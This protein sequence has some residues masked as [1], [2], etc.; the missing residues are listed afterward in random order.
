MSKVKNKIQDQVI[1]FFENDQYYKNIRNMAIIAHVDHG[2]STLT[3][4]LLAHTKMLDAD[5]VGATMTD[6][7]KQERERG[8]TINNATISV[9]DRGTLFNII[10]TPGHVDFGVE[11]AKSLRSIDTAVLVMDCVEGVMVQTEAVISQAIKE[12][13]ELVLLINKVD[14]LIMLKKTPTEIALNFQKNIKNV[15]NLIKKLT[16]MQKSY[17]STD[18][19]VIY[20][21]SL[22]KWGFTLEKPT[23]IDQ[24]KAVID[25]ISYISDCVKNNLDL[26]ESHN[27]ASLVF[28]SVRKLQNPINAHPANIKHHFKDNMGVVTEEFLN[29]PIKDVFRALITDIK[30]DHTVGLTHTIRVLSGTYDRTKPLYASE[31][32]YAN[33]IKK[34]TRYCLA[35]I[36][37]YVEVEQMRAGGI[38]SLQGC[39]LKQIGTT[40]T[41]KEKDPLVYPKIVYMREPILSLTVTPQKLSDLSK[42]IAGLKILCL[43]DPTLNFEYDEASKEFTLAGVGNLHLEVALKKLEQNHNVVVKTGAPK[44][45]YVE[46]LDESTERSETVSVRTPNKH[47]DFQFYLFNLPSNIT[48]KLLK[49]EIS[50]KSLNDELEKELP[51]DLAKAAVK[52]VEKGNI[53]FDMT[54]GADFMEECKTLLTKSLSFTLNRGV[55]LPNM[56]KGLGI[57]LTYAKI[58]E[59]NLHR[60]EIQLRSAFR[61]GVE[62]ILGK[63]N[64]SIVKE[65][66]MRLYV[67][68]PMESVE[69]INI[70]I[71]NK[72]G[73]FINSEAEETSNYV[74]LEY[75][76]PLAECI[77]ISAS[78]MSVTE[79]RAI[80]YTDFEYFEEVPSKILEEIINPKDSNSVKKK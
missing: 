26:S 80:Y 8:I 20:G 65:P 12:N 48:K 10:D 13:V 45:P 1:K 5:S 54:H 35:M 56:L 64:P 50:A 70:L 40:I 25:K 69:A 39:Q 44:I 79:G 32:E 18:K 33:P 47:N 6:V 2:K 77:D 51:K 66:I 16:G 38:Y 43:E 17:F 73:Y 37:K 59:D 52:I 67:R 46:T 23:N 36:D 24:G 34:P 21:S 3:D 72:R 68:A 31:D 53:Y 29:N 60:T 58:H 57:V 76:I 11:V 22:R 74:A 55:K 62:E 7:G 42:M 41:Q 75:L 78:M 9:L 71:N 27:L 61:D 63:K 30:Y 14:R 28:D 4:N 15:N 19:N 49:Q